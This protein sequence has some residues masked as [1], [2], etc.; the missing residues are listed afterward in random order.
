[1]SQRNKTQVT[2]GG[3]LGGGILLCA[4]AS[5]NFLGFA[6]DKRCPGS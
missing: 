4:S 3:T 6:C 2:G 5:D 1:M